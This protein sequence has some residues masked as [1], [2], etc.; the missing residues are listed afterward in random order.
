MSLI[1]ERNTTTEANFRDV[2]TVHSMAGV[3]FLPAA[4][5]RVI[6]RSEHF[7]LTAMDTFAHCGKSIYRSGHLNMSVMENIYFSWWT[8]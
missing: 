5:N 2:A 4:V 1:C 7:Q 3:F 6:Y 8:Y